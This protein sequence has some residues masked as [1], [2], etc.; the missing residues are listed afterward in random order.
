[1]ELTLIRTQKTDISTISTLEID[2]VHECF[3]IEDTDRGLT[4]FMTL[5]EINSIK[6]HG[7]TAIPTGRYKIVLTYSPRFK[8]ILP[9][10]KNVKGFAGIRIHVGNYPKDTEGC[11]LPGTT[12]SVD[13]VLNSK[14]AFAQLFDKI[15]KS[16]NHN[17]TYIMIKSI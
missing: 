14:V 13:C 8:K 11:L 15:I 7:K 12:P 16:S 3:I 4:D 2:G 10:L 1:M 5:E 6:I 9:E 17:N